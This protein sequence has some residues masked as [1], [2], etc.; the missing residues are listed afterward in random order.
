MCKTTAPDMWPLLC[1]AGSG[2]A[3]EENVVRWFGGI[4]E[5]AEFDALKVE[6]ERVGFLGGGEC[7]VVI[8]VPMYSCRLVKII[9]K[10]NTERK[11]T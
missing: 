3:G 8:E 4:G 10:N 5:V 7:R 1:E 6:H 9:K 2:D 11:R